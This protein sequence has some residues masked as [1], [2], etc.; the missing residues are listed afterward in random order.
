MNII[1]N[2][3]RYLSYLRIT[4]LFLIVISPMVTAQIQHK[5]LPNLS[6][7]AELRVLVFSA[8]GWY[9]HV[10]IPEINDGWFA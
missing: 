1:T 2:L 10:E 4:G 6:K 9:R 5:S 3:F 8:T 7:N